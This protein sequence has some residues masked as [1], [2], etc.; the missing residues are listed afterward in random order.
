MLIIIIISSS[1]SSSSSGRKAGEEQLEKLS[2][3]SSF[4]FSDT[5]LNKVIKI[6]QIYLSQCFGS[7]F[8]RVKAYETFETSIEFE[9]FNV[10]S[11]ALVLVPKK[12]VMIS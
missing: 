4:S 9:G 3:F 11:L 12:V 5:A 6:I 10:P 1:S 7:I 2:K 8:N